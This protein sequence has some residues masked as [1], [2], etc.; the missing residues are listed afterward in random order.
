MPIGTY[1]VRMTKG[2]KKFEEK[3][4]THLDRR[5][6]YTAAD[7]K[8]QYEAALRVRDLFGEMSDLVFKINAVR[9][10]ADADAAKVK[11]NDALHA[12]LTKLSGDA[13]E[14]RR[15][16][17]GDEGGWRDHRRTAPA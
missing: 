14:I 8:A 16:D 5:A 10:Q 11:G 7:R 9:A 15:K 3:L 13:D 1:T 17:R 12:Q 6:T 4:E 2:D